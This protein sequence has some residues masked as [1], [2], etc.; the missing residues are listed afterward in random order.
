MQEFMRWLEG[1]LAVPKGTLNE[2]TVKDD[3][4]SWDSLMQM[5]I[6]MEVDD[7]YDAEIPMDKIG[8][9]SSVKELGAIFRNEKITSFIQ[10]EY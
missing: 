1:I 3:I 8:E 4:E 10:C 2:E 6:A 9:I 7:K 5:R